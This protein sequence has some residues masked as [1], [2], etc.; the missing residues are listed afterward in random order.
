MGIGCTVD[1]SHSAV[2]SLTVKTSVAKRRVCV[3]IQKHTFHYGLHCININLIMKLS[4]FL[5]L[6]DNFTNYLMR[7]LPVTK[8]K[9]LM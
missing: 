7:C 9:E 1:W 3:T 4:I 2:G 5:C 8:D 6:H